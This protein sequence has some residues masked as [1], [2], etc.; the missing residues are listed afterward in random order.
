VR[1]PPAKARSR[2]RARV[3]PPPAKV[4]DAPGGARPLALG[5]DGGCRCEAVA[6]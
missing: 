2:R 4:G 1:P 6:R 3:L 5:C